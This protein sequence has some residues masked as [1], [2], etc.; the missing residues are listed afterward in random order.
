[1]DYGLGIGYTPCG[2]YTQTERKGS[3]LKTRLSKHHLRPKSL[4]G[5]NDPD[6]ISLVPSN[7]HNWWHALFENKSVEQIVE[8]I[9]RHWIPRDYRL[10][11]ERTP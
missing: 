10:R 9:N 3:T 2:V 6:N 11:V 8:D 7:R 4:G 1:L 5:T